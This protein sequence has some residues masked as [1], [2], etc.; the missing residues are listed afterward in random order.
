MRNEQ[1]RASPRR[2][3]QC[4]DNGPFGV[5]IQPAGWFIQD[6]NGGTTQNGSGNRD[7]LFLAAGKCGAT[8]GEQG[9]IALWEHVNELR[10]IRYNRGLDNLLVAGVW[11]S[12]SDVFADRPAEEQGVLQNE[13]NLPAQGLHQIVSDVFTVNQDGA[14][15]GII[16]PWNQAD[17]SALTRAVRSY[18][19]NFF[20][21]SNAQ[22]D[23]GKDRLP[24]FVFER[25]IAKL[26]FSLKSRHLSSSGMI[27]YFGT[28]AHDVRD[29]LRTPGGFTRDEGK[30]RQGFHRAIEVGD[31]RKKHHHIA[32]R[33]TPLHH[34]RGAEPHHQRKACSSEKV[35]ER[36]HTRLIADGFEIG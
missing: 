7:P 16:E 15:A 20:T 4:I 28:H 27:R 19:R 34:M 5:G 1:C 32:S 24:R 8:L 12:E 36:R 33:E 17:E 29:S 30:S 21:G 14:A 11:T 25:N 18:N 22:I 26:D 3:F 6:Q 9:F 31:V 35:D 2:T 23:P 10:G 13:A